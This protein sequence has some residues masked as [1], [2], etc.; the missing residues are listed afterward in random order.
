MTVLA[1]VA[2]LFSVST[3]E[4]ISTFANPPAGNPAIV[5]IFRTVVQRTLDAPSFRYNQ[6]LNYQAPDRTATLRTLGSMKV[7][8][9][10]AYI[11]LTPG[12]PTG[13]WG[14]GPLT[15]LVDS[16]YGPAM[17]LHGLRTLLTSNSVIREGNNFVVKQVVSADSVSP[18]NPGQVLVT[19]M[20]YVNDDYVTAIQTRLEGWWSIPYARING[21]LRFRRVDTFTASQVTYS[22]FGQIAPITAPPAD[23]TLQLTLCGQV[24]HLPYLGREVCSAF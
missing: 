17:A 13:K 22:S 16:Y 20:V 24:Y 23:R 12:V 6:Y 3:A 2:L 5:T 8:G 9:K 1:L 18:G 10:E 7:I 14:R 15:P 11:L 21:I 19:Y 4:R